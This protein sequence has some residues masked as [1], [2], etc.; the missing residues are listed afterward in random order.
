MFC[1]TVLSDKEGQ[2]RTRTAV[3]G[4]TL[5]RMRDSLSK[6]LKCQGPEEE[7]LEEPRIYGLPRRG[8]ALK[9]DPQSACGKCGRSPG[10]ESKTERAL[11]SV[12]EL[13]LR[14]RHIRRLVSYESCV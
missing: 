3:V 5:A 2:L 14:R 6:A 8:A 9:Q 11:R 1:Q 4:A 13:E 7:L 12:G 10:W